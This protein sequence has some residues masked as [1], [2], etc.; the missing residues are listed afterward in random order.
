[1]E[2]S[3]KITQQVVENYLYDF[4]ET[5]RKELNPF[6][7]FNIKGGLFNFGAFFIIAPH[8]DEK[9]I[10]F[11]P[12]SV[13]YIFDTSLDTSQK[14]ILDAFNAVGIDLIQ[15]LANN[16]IENLKISLKANKPYFLGTNIIYDESVI[17]FIKE[18]NNQAWHS[19]AAKKDVQRIKNEI[20]E[21][22]PSG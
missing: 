15:C 3:F 17:I 18:A 14:T 2:N 20:R 16:E 9:I 11:D 22:P 6:V 13:N 10:E 7:K 12:K 5:A 21:L 19:E 4:H 8:P 1:L